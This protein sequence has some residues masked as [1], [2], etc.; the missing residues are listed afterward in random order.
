[1]GKNKNAKAKKKVAE[2]I[3]RFSERYI[4][5]QMTL[6]DAEWITEQLWDF[7]DEALSQAVDLLTSPDKNTRKAI[8]L[9]LEELDDPRAVKPLRRMLRNPDYDDEE[10]MRVLYVLEQLG[11]R[12]DEDTY[13]RAISDPEALMR[14]SI[15][16]LL[17][18]IE[19]PEQVDTFLAMLTERPPE[20]IEYYLREVLG[21]LADR[22]LLLL[23]TALL[24]SEH[25]EVILAAIDTL[26]TLKEPA[27]IAL[28]QERA[29]YDPS[30]KVRHAA[31]NAALR[32]QTRIGAPGGASG[33]RDT[34]L[35]WIPTPSL[36]LA[37]C[38]LSTTD[39]DGGQVLLLARERPAGNLQTLDVMFNDH[40][41]IKDCFSVVI[42]EEDLN[43]MIDSFS[44]IDFVDVRLERA[45]E[46]II[47]ARQTTL[48]AHRRLPP[49]FVAWQGEL[50][51][52]D[53]RSIEELPLPDIEPAQEES[54]L[55][56]CIELLDLDEFVYWFFN[57]DEVED[58]VPRYR[59]LWRRNQAERGQKSFEALLDQAIESVIDDDYRRLLADRLRRQAWLLAQL[60]EDAEVP[61][62]ALAAAIAL[63]NGVTVEHPL[64]REM[65]AYS[66]FNATE[67]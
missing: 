1:M 14:N 7:P 53:P 55:A 21:P 20:M 38:L 65:M 17:E 16:R 5:N 54:L 34:L 62:W 36:P 30:R 25:D 57:P 49:T 44:P 10:K 28:L 33:E 29:E 2:L 50:W 3:A 60:Y 15:D 4:S 22:R 52:E 43:D 6:E 46:A 19:E 42:D 32:L 63:E 12:V 13:R 64:L 58:F 51:G 31:E 47:Q 41:G 27:T 35:P 59:K 48:D 67:P 23:A 11:A 39:G 26:E 9:L 61:Q 56:Q 24:H 45:R 37:H 40:Q 8:L 18:T 66:L